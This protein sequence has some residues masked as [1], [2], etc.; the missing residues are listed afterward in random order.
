MVGDFNPQTKIL[1]DQDTHYLELKPEYVGAGEIRKMSGQ[2]LVMFNTET[3]DPI[4]YPYYY[5]NGLDDI[6]VVLEKI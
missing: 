6:F 2:L 4:M 1:F 5:Q 3:A